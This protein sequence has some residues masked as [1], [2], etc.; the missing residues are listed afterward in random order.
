MSS[1]FSTLERL[2]KLAKT[3]WRALGRPAPDSGSQSHLTNGLPDSTP[4]TVHSERVNGVVEREA[5]DDSEESLE[6][7]HNRKRSR[8]EEDDSPT[9]STVQSPKKKTRR[10]K[11]TADSS[12]KS[13]TNE[14][15]IA[16]RQKAREKSGK[17]GREKPKEDTPKSHLVEKSMSLY[18][19]V[20]PI[21]QVYNHDGIIAYNLPGLLLNYFAPFRGIPISYK[22]PRLS[23]SP[24][25]TEPR[26]APLARTMGIYGL[27]YVWLTA[28]FLVL[29]PQKGVNIEG[30]I[31]SQSE[32]HLNLICWNILTATIERKRLPQAWRWI[33]LE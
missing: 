31:K 17:R 18:V 33:Q 20:P 16:H 26:D 30:Y 10:S 27:S 12:A 3:P 25:S 29:V 28:D 13:V 21:C 32:T 19:P 14:T 23:E 15:T 2:S 4:I 22:N 9:G 1:Q 5:E 8:E 6:K 7:A 11:A 24:E